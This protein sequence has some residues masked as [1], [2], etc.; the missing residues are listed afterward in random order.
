[1]TTAESTIVAL[2]AQVRRF[3]AEE[4]AAGSFRPSCDCWV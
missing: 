4:L 1:M 3:L 2:R